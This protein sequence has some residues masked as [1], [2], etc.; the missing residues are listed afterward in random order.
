MEKK[1]L[2]GIVVVLLTFGL[3]DTL[4]TIM[5][6]DKLGVETE[7]AY[8]ARMVITCYGL[9][10]LMV[11][12]AIGT[13]LLCFLIYRLYKNG[14]QITAHSIAIL[15]SIIGILITVNNALAITCGYTLF[16]ISYIPIATIAILIFVH[17]IENNDFS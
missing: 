10:G 16:F 3:G 15:A 7:G 13:A 4:T 14:F 9:C 11:L 17:R 2:F 8:F 5:F 1:L 12:K 6:I